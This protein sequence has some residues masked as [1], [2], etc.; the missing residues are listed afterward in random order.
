[1]L[2]TAVNGPQWSKLLLKNIK[3]VSTIKQSIQADRVVLLETVI[4][5]V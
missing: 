1:M 3:K 5:I 4:A 2:V